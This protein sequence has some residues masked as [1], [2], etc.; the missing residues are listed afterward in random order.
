MN[1]NSIFRLKVQYKAENQETGDVEKMKL[2]I[3]TQCVN[4]TDA[5]A[6]MNK[7][8]EQYQMNKFEPCTYDIVKTKFSANDIYGCKTLSADDSK[9]LTCGLL[10]HFFEESDGLYAV[11]NIVFGN[12]EDKE[13]DL[14]RTFFIPAKDTAD[15]TSVAIAI[16]QYEGRDLNDCLISSVKLD[17]AEYVYLRPK[18]SEEAFKL[19][20][21]IFDF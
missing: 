9:N 18:T 10:Q 17:H 14:K 21:N 11:D 16:L 6:V 5:E 4:Y 20:T 2:E 19:A 7:I 1:E 3:L 13:K 8:I 15:A 12:K